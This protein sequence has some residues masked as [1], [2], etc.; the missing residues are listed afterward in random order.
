MGK[1]TLYQRLFLGIKKGLLTPTLPEHII[2]LQNNVFIRLLRVLGGISLIL[3]VTHRLDSL[4]DGLFYIFCIYL[5]LILNVMFSIYILY[6][7]NHRIKHMYKLLKSDALYVHNS[8]YDKFASNTSK[9][10]W[11][12]KGF[13]EGAAPI[14]IF[15]GSMAGFDELMKIRGHE[16]KFKPYISSMIIPNTE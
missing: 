3:T 4:G 15:Y 2:A 11:C 13:C 16:P 5:C 10:L 7:N 6:R 8:P 1:R 9:L 14:G 12:T